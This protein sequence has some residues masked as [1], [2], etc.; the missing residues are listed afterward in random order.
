MNK[1]LIESIIKIL[2]GM[3]LVFAAMTG[4]F[5]PEGTAAAGGALFLVGL[6]EIPFRL[7]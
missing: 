3:V 4:G 1:L 2:V 5:F 7:P 6:V